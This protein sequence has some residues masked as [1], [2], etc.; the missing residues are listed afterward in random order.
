MTEWMKMNEFYYEYQYSS[1]YP[2]SAQAK[3]TPN[4]I[5]TSLRP[6]IYTPAQLHKTYANLSWINTQHILLIL[7]ILRRLTTHLFNW[8]GFL[9]CFCWP[10]WLLVAGSCSCFVVRLEDVLS[11]S[12]CWSRPV[13]LATFSRRLNAERRSTLSVPMLNSKTWNLFVLYKTLLNF[14]K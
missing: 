7:F 5:M 4:L 10:N 3:D 11:T 14:G 13:D 9:T 12:A 8:S 6:I 1:T 2:T